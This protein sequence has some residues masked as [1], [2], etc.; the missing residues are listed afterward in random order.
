[1]HRNSR[2]VSVSGTVTLMLVLVNGTILA[3]GL[4]DNR[5]WYKLLLFTL[6]ALLI[7]L[8]AGSRMRSR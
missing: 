3:A 2:E 7:A 6:P 5:A 1:M 4:T 8:I